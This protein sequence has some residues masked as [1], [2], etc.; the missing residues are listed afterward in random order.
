MNLLDKHDSKCLVLLAYSKTS[1]KKK[2]DEE[3]REESLES[4]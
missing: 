3:K 4:N 2:N 1:S